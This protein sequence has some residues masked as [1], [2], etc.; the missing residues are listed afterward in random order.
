MA[1]ENEIARLRERNARIGLQ[2]D[3]LA[4]EAALDSVLALPAAN[5][6]IDEL[7]DLWQAAAGLNHRLMKREQTPA[8]KAA[9]KAILKKFNPQ[10]TLPK[11]AAL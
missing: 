6:L 10:F 5:R 1:I 7:S 11:G 3:V 2:L 4:R 9:R 8:G